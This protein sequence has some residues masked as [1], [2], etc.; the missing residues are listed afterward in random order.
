MF[1][2]IAKIDQ[3]FGENSASKYE[4]LEKVGNGTYGV[5]YKAKDKVS[6]EIVALKKM[7]LEVLKN[8]ILFKY[9][10]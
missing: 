9:F 10:I 2:K 6:D 1:G 7:I 4:K 5:V 8:I 3:N